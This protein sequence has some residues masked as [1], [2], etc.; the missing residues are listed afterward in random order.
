MAGIGF[1]LQKLFQ[2]DYYSSRLKAY[3]FSG[4]VTSGP[5]LIV[6]LVVGTIQW[7]AFQMPMLSLEERTLFM[8]SVSYAFIFSQIL[9]SFQQLV[10]TR[11]V[12]D[13]FY[14][15]KAHD[16]F[17]VFTGMLKVTMLAAII[18]YSIFWMISPLDFLYKLVLFVLFMTINVIWVM[19]LFLSA[20]KFYQAIAYSFLLGG[21]IA[22]GGVF[23]IS[24]ILVDPTSLELLLGFTVGML[25]TLFG[26]FFA[27]LR[28]F[29]LRYATNE[30]SYFRY[31]D[32]YPDLF[33]IG[34]LYVLGIWVTNFIIWFGEGRTV[35]A[36]SF[37]FNP[38][39]DTAVFWSYLTIVPTQLLFVVAVET[40]FYE[41][42]RTFYGLIN[43]G[44]ALHQIDKAKQTMTTVLKNELIRLGRSQGVVTLFAILMAGVFVGWI[45][46]PEEVGQIFRMTTLAAFANAMILVLTLLLLYF[47]DRRGALFV[48]LSFF[49]GNA[50]FT[51]ALLP[52]G[53]DWYGVGFAVST[54][55]TFFIAGLRLMYFM[56][57]V[58]Y[59]VFASSN[60]RKLGIERFSQMGTA[61]NRRFSR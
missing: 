48:N 15:K 49:T 57:K 24:R 18:M 39:Y 29:P 3:T 56:G 14:E 13:L 58:D 20:A 37:V 61:L 28:T 5:W 4:L 21:F 36:E 17:P 47:E 55:I 41:R 8:L 23:L 60:R 6:I 52:L 27:M 2:E 51:L 16:I 38:Y 59:Y 42:Y 54:T 30:F 9:F 50:L 44:G 12:A 11:Y 26:L 33:A 22:I 19:F 32:L 31:F 40:R 7:L 35:V 25:V 34:V 46:V 53:I 43:Y 45:G 10:V 1:K